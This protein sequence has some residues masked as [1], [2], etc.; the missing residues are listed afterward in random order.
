MQICKLYEGAGS[1]TCNVAEYRGI[2]LGLRH[3]L[4]MGYRNIQVQGDSKLICMQVGMER[5][6]NHL[7]DVFVFYNPELEFLL[8]FLLNFLSSFPV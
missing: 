7:I 2:I 3:A 6:N 1:A 8:R 4:E 5:P